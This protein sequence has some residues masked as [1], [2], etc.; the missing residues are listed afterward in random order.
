MFAD[1][2]HNG[3]LPTR[4]AIRP[5]RYQPAAQARGYGNPRLRYG[6]VSLCFSNP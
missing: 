1:D 6:L 3:C 5:E 4:R 2:P